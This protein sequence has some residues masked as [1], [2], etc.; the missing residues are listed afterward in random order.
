MKDFII[1]FE[2]LDT[3][4]SAKVAIISV[5]FFDSDCEKRYNYWRI[6]KK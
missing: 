5:V 1:D 3:V 6:R 2:T 4:P